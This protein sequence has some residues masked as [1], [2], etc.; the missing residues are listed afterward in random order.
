MDSLKRKLSA[1]RRPDANSGDTI[2]ELNMYKKSCEALQRQID[3]LMVKLNDSQAADREKQNKLDDARAKLEEYEKNAS[4]VAHGEKSTSALQNTVDHLEYRLQMANIEKVELE[5]HLW[6]LQRMRHIFDPKSPS[7]LPLPPV[8]RQSMSTIFANDSPINESDPS[9]PKSVNAFLDR[10]ECLNQQLRTKDKAMAATDVELDGLRRTIDGLEDEA[11]DLRLQLDI[12]TQLLAKTKK[13]E[14][15]MHELRTTIMQREKVIGDR[16]GELSTLKTQLDHHKQLLQAG[17]K[18]QA[19]YKLYGEVQDD[20]PDLNTLASKYDIDRWIEGLKS[21]L[22]QY[23]AKTAGLH[24]VDS[25]KTTIE[26]LREEI[27]FYVSEIIYFKLDC[28]GY[29]LDIKKLKKTVQQMSSQ[30]S[31]TNDVDSPD[32]SGYK[33][34]NGPADVQVQA[35]ASGLGISASPSSVSTGRIS[36]NPSV[37]RP[38]T[39]SNTTVQEPVRADG[40]NSSPKRPKKLNLRVSTVPRTPTRQKGTNTANQADNVDPGIS[41]RSVA[42][43]SPERRKPTVRPSSPKGSASILTALAA[44][45]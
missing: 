40:A 8:D 19:M 17:V 10:I 24:S 26:E 31:G 44:L 27:D 1:A 22:K 45:A 38:T 29:K 13:D 2:R 33:P 5:E 14:I 35:G 11:R 34:I 18:R 3:L 9:D 21:R 16:N 41:P 20:L 12:Q 37:D 25:P 23:K 43:L 28:R 6:H 30:S 15:H 7:T 39:P 4:K 32:L 36:I 42:R